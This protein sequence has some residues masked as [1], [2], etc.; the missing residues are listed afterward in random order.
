MARPGDTCV[1]HVSFAVLSAWSHTCKA[2]SFCS[3]PIIPMKP[4]Y[5]FLTGLSFLA[6]CV[7]LALPAVSCAAPTAAPGS[8]QV[9]APS[10]S[11]A[12]KVERFGLKPSPT[13]KPAASAEQ[14]LL[15]GE[16]PGV[17]T[18]SLT[19]VGPTQFQEAS[20]QDHEVI[21]FFLDGKGVLKTR[22]NNYEVT[23]PTIARAPLG[24]PWQIEVKEGESLLVLRIRKALSEPDRSDR[25][26]YPQNNTAPWVRKFSECPTYGEAIKSAKTISRTL[27]PENIVPRMAAGTVETNG[28][29]EVAPHRHPML[30]QLFLGLGVN[31]STVTADGA[32]ADFPAHSLLHIPVG[33]SHGTQ[34]AAGKKLYYVWLDFFTTKEGQEWL[35]THKPTPEKK[36]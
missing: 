12:I 19:L 3:L 30:E 1:T 23:E 27:L 11:V 17:V 7:W 33:S 5:S 21:W 25:L 32:K 20:S 4:R 24:W 31:D 34:V 8:P 18:D 26:N 13:V 16:I 36:M 35:M 15:Q 10:G 22:E 29:D 2:S 6:S 14:A 28:P 9:D